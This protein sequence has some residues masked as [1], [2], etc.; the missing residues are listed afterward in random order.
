MHNNVTVNAS[1]HVY[2]LRVHLS[3]DMSLGKHVSSVSVTCFYHFRQLRRIRRS[4]DADSAATLVHAFVTSRVD[5]CKAIL[6]AAPKTTTDRLQRVLNAAA[7]VV[8]DT[9][10]FDYRSA[11][12][13][14]DAPGV[15]LAG[16]SRACKLQAESADPP[17]STRQGANVPIKL[18]HSSQSSSYTAESTFRCTSS[19][20][21]NSTSSQHL[22]SPG[23]CC[24]WSDD[25]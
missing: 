22:R 2:V 3:S 16:H 25:V 5:Y 4:F 15:T 6:A 9:K 20:D 24:R 1:Q 18:L 23:I 7:R 10:K 12:I 14:T 13:T 8:N 21:R 17:V 19:A 11:T